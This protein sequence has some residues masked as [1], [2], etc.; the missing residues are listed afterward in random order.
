[1]HQ[2]AKFHQSQSELLQRYGDLTV[3]KMAAVR[4]LGFFLIKIFY[5]SKWLRDPFCISVP[6]FVK[7][8]ETIAQKSQFL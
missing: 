3:Y 6:N 5:R 1:M 2:R 7:I 4:H 8:G